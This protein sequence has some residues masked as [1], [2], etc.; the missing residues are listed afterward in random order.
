MIEITTTTATV[1][2]SNNGHRRWLTRKAAYNEAAWRAYNAK[3]PRTYADSDWVD[4]YSVESTHVRE[5]RNNVVNRLVRWLMWRDS[6]KEVKRWHQTSA[7]SI[8]Y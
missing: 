5:Y 4:G 1:Y 2:Q 7:A 6:K 3:Y 8:G